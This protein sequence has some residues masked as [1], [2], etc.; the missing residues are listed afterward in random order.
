MYCL[1]FGIYHLHI[2]QVS[3]N[4]HV[5]VGRHVLYYMAYKVQQMPNLLFEVNTSWLT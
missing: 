5:P 2:S 4:I 3:S 1:K